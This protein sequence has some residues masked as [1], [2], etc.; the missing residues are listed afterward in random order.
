MKYKQLYR[1][2]WAS[3]HVHINVIIWSCIILTITS[4]AP[5]RTGTEENPIEYDILEEQG[6]GVII[7]NVAMDSG[8]ENRYSAQTLRKLTYSFLRNPSIDGRE[9]FEIN[10]HS[11]I[12]KVGS[13]LIV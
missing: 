7:G 10:A 3:L 11:G 2:M 5:P 9:R 1:K 13:F 4:A 6:A 8:L 12:I